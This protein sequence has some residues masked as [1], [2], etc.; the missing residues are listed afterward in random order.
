MLSDSIAVPIKKG[1]AVFMVF[2]P[3]EARLEAA[4]GAA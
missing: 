4:G 2:L 3:F 1:G